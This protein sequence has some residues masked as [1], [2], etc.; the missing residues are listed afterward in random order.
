MAAKT[1]SLRSKISGRVVV[2][3][4]YLSNVWITGSTIIVTF[5]TV[6]LGNFLFCIKSVLLETYFRY[7]R[8]TRTHTRTHVRTH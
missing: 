7:P 2:V 8:Y 3:L 5:C 6:I 4:R 1:S